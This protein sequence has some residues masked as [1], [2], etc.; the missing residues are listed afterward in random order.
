MKEKAN[1]ISTS[2]NCDSLFLVD[3]SYKIFQCYDCL[4][5][6]IRVYYDPDI[7]IRIKKRGKDDS[8]LETSGHH[9]GGWRRN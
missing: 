9:W 7:Y 2:C 5:E 3:T 4:E 6:Y 8:C 1:F